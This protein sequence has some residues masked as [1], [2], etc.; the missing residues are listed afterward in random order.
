M[1]L[2]FSFSRG[3]L[4]CFRF[5]AFGDFG[6]FPVEVVLAA[7][8]GMDRM[9]DGVEGEAGG[10]TGAFDKNGKKRVDKSPE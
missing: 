5:V 1:K 10:S 7:F 6:S 4:F 3:T 2:F 9:E 8:D